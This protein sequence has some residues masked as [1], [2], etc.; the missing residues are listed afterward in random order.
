MFNI[1]SFPTHPA[2]YS[3]GNDDDKLSESF[4]C[5][6]TANKAICVLS[7]NLWDQAAH[8]FMVDD[9]KVSRK[10]SLRSVSHASLR[11]LF[12]TSQ[13]GSCIYNAIKTL[14]ILAWVGKKSSLA[15]MAKK[16]A[17]LELMKSQLSPWTF[18]KTLMDR[19][20]EVFQQKQVKVGKTF[21]CPKSIC[22]TRKVGNIYRIDSNT[23]QNIEPSMLIG[24]YHFTTL[25]AKTFNRQLRRLTKSPQISRKS[26]R[27][28]C[29]N[30]LPTRIEQKEK[31]PR[32]LIKFLALFIN[33]VIESSRKVFF[34][35]H[36]TVPQG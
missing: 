34:V 35:I 27:V 3:C 10:S 14:L 4:L 17:K 24:F 20:L 31:L 12:G 6:A 28:C 19:M 5:V 8:Y 13:C 16:F 11:S 29:C 7:T 15:V 32:S 23:I 2:C 25:S 30:C 9:I 18:R 36:P 22:K 1:F 21:W 26:L 33:C